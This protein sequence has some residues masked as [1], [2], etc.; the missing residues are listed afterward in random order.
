MKILCVW[1][2]EYISDSYEQVQYLPALKSL[3]HDAK[4]LPIN[5]FT[6]ER[7]IDI[8]KAWKPELAIFKVYRDLMRL[9]PIAYISQYTNTTTVT[10]NGDD[11][12]LFDVNKMWDSV[13]IS[14]NFNYIV[15]T[16]KDAVKKYEQIGFKN[17]I[18]SQY[19]C[20][21]EYCRK[22]R[23]KKVIDVAFLGTRKWSRVELFNYLANHG[24]KLKVYGMGW[25]E[26]ESDNR[27]LS[28]ED[29]IWVMNKT[30]INLN[31]QID[32]TKKGEGDV[33]KGKKTLQIKGRDFEVPMTGGFLLTD[34]NENL[35]EFFKFGK[36][37]ET[38]KDK[39]ECLSKIRY[40]L[41]H[42][43]KREKIAQAGYRRARK[44]HTYMKRFKRILDL[45]KLKRGVYEKQSI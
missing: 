39:A 17:V 3:G 44:D 45:I 43:D 32:I 42:E 14:P 8:V 16:C 36:E 19:G 35:K 23:T 25:A 24:V 38:Y 12:K 26:K 30:K 41:K 4:L 37:I 2:R 18:F 33:L 11:E 5:D 28:P 34:Y 9:E 20:N 21:H 31:T 40:Y 10:I 7:I 1:V 22:I 29:Y 27:T 15:T 6:N 13:H